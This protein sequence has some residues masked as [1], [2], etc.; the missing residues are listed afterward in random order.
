MFLR[1]QFA[2]V[3][4]YGLAQLQPGLNT[5]VLTFLAVVVMA[6]GCV[7]SMV[8]TFQAMEAERRPDDA[9]IAFVAAL[10]IAVILIVAARRLSSGSEE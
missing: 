9:I 7:N 8:R 3:Q 2:P 10:V 4:S 6:G 5:A 1:Q